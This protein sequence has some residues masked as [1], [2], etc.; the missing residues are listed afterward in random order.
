[1]QENEDD[2]DIGS[3]QLQGDKSNSIGVA[4]MLA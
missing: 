3:D 1:M 2:A 4:H